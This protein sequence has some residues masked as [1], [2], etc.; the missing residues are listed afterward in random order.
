M[1]L[2]LAAV[3]MYFTHRRS[4]E[5]AKKTLRDEENRA[6]RLS[7]FRR[8]FLMCLLLAL[9]GFGVMIG[10]FI[11]EEEHPLMFAVLWIIL[12][13]LTLAVA[14]LAVLDLVSIRRFALHL[15]RELSEEQR[16]LEA[17]IRQTRLRQQ[18]REQNGHGEN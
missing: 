15:S 14:V 10:Q 16:K 12:T 7:Q 4:W 6:Y 11:P 5:E 8:R 2:W 13:L 3:A 1:G 9:L 17:E 18:L